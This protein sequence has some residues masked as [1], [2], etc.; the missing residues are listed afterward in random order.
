M[1]NVEDRRADSQTGFEF[2]NQRAIPV[3]TGIVVATDQ[4]D[5]VMDAYEESAQAA[6]ERERIKKEEKAL[7]RWVKLMNGLR[8]RRRLQAEYGQS[9]NVRLFHVFTIKIG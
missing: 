8:V 2:K 7:K 9:D 3:I 6:Q 5:L 4:K 1:S